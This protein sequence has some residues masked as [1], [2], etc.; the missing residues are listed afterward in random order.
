MMMEEKDSTSSPV[1]SKEAGKIVQETAHPD[2]KV[3]TFDEN[4]SPEEKKQHVSAGGPTASSSGGVEGAGEI[5]SVVKNN[6]TSEKKMPTDAQDKK[7]EQ[8][9]ILKTD[10]DDGTKVSAPSAATATAATPPPSKSKSGSRVVPGGFSVDNDTICGWTDLSSL[11][12]PGQ[13]H[14]M[15]ALKKSLTDEQIAAIYS[16]SRLDDYTPDHGLLGQ[17]LSDTYYGKWFHNAGALILAV[18]FTFILTKVGTGLFACLTIGA[19]LATYYQ[20]STRRLRRNIRDDVQ[21][22]MTMRQLESDNESV[23][24]MNHFLSRFWLIYEPV[25]SAQ[26]IGTADAILS[27]NCPSF[28]DSLRLTTFTLGTKAP[29][30]EFVKTYPRTEPNIVVSLVTLHDIL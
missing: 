18:V 6:V 17:L 19:F 5:P 7:N 16:G 27:E 25:L 3:H 9:D 13:D 24:W 8:K 23:N 28:L 14:L 10:S 29:H 22:E 15:V 1:S 4:M 11:P 20:T 21:R 12:N 2:A 26:I 30:I